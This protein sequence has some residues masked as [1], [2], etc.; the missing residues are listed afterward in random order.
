[1]QIDDITNYILNW[2]R[3]WTLDDLLAVNQFAKVPSEG[4][5]TTALEN[6]VGTDVA[7][8]VTEI[9]AIQGDPLNGQTLYNGALG[10][11]GCH[12]NEVV[13]PLTQNTWPALQSGER[14]SDSALA[15]YTP[16]QYLVESIV[17]PQAYTVPGYAQAMPQNFGERLDAQMLADIIA[18]IKSYDGAE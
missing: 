5:A 12:S 16:E 17:Q 7:A 11:A 10:C 18:Y 1:D 14:L 6:P 15:G 8:I 4:G 3:E 2:N 9:G 13:A